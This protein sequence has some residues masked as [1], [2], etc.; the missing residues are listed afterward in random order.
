MV[1]CAPSATHEHLVKAS[2]VGLP[3]GGEKGMCPDSASQVE[4]LKDADFS[5]L[6][7]FMPLG[8]LGWGNVTFM[9]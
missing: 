2:F 4:T 5:R 1:S 8:F 7:W 3:A 9:L 6:I